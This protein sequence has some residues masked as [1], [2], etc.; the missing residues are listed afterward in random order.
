M[1]LKDPL[2]GEGQHT[3]A[4]QFPIPNTLANVCVASY[5]HTSIPYNKFNTM[6]RNHTTAIGLLCC[7]ATALTLFRNPTLLRVLKRLADGDEYARTGD[8]LEAV[9]AIG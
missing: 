2:A 8:I 4:S 1:T 3:I 7:I 9:R 6:S 5:E